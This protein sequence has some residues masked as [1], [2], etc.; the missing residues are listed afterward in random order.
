MYNKQGRIFRTDMD[1]GLMFNCSRVVVV[2][3]L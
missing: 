3:S 1:A 2:V